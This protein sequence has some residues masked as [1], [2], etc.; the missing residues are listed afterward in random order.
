MKALHQGTQGGI[1]SLTPNL[2]F[3]AK[4]CSPASFLFRVR[5]HDCFKKR[6]ANSKP[7]LTISALD[8]NFF[9]RL[10]FP[11][12][13]PSRFQRSI[14]VPFFLPFRL[15]HLC[16]VLYKIPGTIGI[17]PVVEVRTKFRHPKSDLSYDLFILIKPAA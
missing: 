17:R 16:A 5:S 9:W 8:G 6:E 15:V 14:P 4:L 11:Y 2:K 3:A 12:F 10:P 13:L 7:L 1:R